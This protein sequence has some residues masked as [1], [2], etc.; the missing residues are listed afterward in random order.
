MRDSI[1]LE[2]ETALSGIKR[3][4]DEGMTIWSKE[5]FKLLFKDA[6]GYKSPYIIGKIEELQKIGTLIF[7]KSDDIYIEIIKI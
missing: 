4:Y 1:E 2:W 7:K 3:F 5:N 6:D